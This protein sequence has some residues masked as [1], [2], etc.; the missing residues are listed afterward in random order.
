MCDWL[1]C[2]DLKHD[3]LKGI[4]TPQERLVETNIAAE[5]SVSHSILRVV[6]T[7]L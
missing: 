1:G 3:I 7:R 6:L 5:L 4:Y 2:F